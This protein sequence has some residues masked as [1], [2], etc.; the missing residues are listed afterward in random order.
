MEKI[1]TISIAAYNVEKYIEKA[2]SS[3]LIPS[4]DKLEIL[5]QDDGSKD[6][7]YIISKKYEEKYPKSI[8][9]IKK[10][11]GGYGSTIN[12]SIKMA[13]G[14]YFKQL[15]GDDWYDTDN[16]ELLVKELEKIDV[17]VIY[18]PYYKIFEINNKLQIIDNIFQNKKGIYEL[19]NV[20]KDFCGK[21]YKSLAMHSL[22]FSTKLLKENKIK[23]L[24]K[25]FYTDNEFVLYPL[26][27]AKTIY[28][29]HDLKI[30]YYRIGREGQ[31]ISLE[32]RRKNYR[33]ILKVSKK[34][35]EIIPSVESEKSFL[36]DYIF[37]Y[38][39]IILG[40][41]ILNFLLVL[42]LSVENLK[43]IKEFDLYI[44]DKNIFLYKKMEEKSKTIFFLRKSLYFLYP[45]LHY[46]AI[47]KIKKGLKNE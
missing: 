34:S 24:E 28:I 38:I 27:Y 25:C 32:S 16:L 36:K 11:N 19:E 1:L 45:I 42:S 13:T 2:L 3:L 22:I 44:K 23:C 31:S 33:D 39:S 10:E 41:S 15:D 47:I 35:L 14:K 7:T 17:D 43:K 29:N 40:S 12:S 46:R 30:Y 37:E 4:I 8:K 20:V 18:T 5:V 21:N 9:V 26:I 6:D